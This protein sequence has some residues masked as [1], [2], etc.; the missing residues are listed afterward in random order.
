MLVDLHC[1]RPKRYSR[2]QN[3]HS[4]LMGFTFRGH[5]FSLNNHRNNLE[6]QALAMKVDG[7]ERLYCRSWFKLRSHCHG[8]GKC[9]SEAEKAV[10]WWCKD[11]CV[12]DWKHLM[13]M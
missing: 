8:R 13:E 7:T 12:G 1:A 4:V 9:L 11:L 3:R 5:G 6:V 2:D 10:I